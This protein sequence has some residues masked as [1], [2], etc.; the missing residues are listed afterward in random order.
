MIRINITIE[1]MC[2]LVV[3]QAFSNYCKCPYNVRLVFGTTGYYFEVYSILTG[4]VHEVLYSVEKLNDYF[5]KGA[6]D[7][8]G[9][10]CKDE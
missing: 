7:G 1:Q 4:A 3:H 2:Q 10:A 8:K 5:L 9:P 6:E